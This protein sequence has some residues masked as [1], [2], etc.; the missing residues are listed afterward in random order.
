MLFKGRRA[1]TATTEFR[2]WRDGPAATSIPATARTAATLST[3][4]LSSA[5]YIDFRARNLSDAD[6]LALNT[7]DFMAHI[8]KAVINPGGR[9]GR[10]EILDSLKLPAGARVLEIGCGTGETACFIAQ[11]YACDVVAIDVSS[12]MVE[13]ANDRIYAQGLQDRIQCRVADVMKLPFDDNSFD[14]VI[15][16]AVLMFV[17][18]AAALREIQR[19]LR[20]GGT[21]AGLEFSW[22]REPIPAVRATTYAICG[23]RTLE[24]YA[25]REWRTILTQGG[26]AQCEARERRFNML[27]SVGFVRDEGIGNSLKIAARLVGRKARLQRMAQIWRHF[28]R[29]RAYFSYTVLRAEKARA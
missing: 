22:K 21:F 1:R 25:T 26:F 2:P 13:G 18:K 12:A 27:S 17:D 29:H 3:A 5:C 28:S 23:C 16:Q 19:V 4:T 20:P 6:I 7:Y 15:C 10:D 11:R 24:F 14:Y 8:G 9:S